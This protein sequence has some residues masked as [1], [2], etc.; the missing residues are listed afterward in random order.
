MQMHNSSGPMRTAVFFAED[1]GTENAIIDVFSLD[2]PS[3]YV[4]AATETQE[5][6][7]WLAY[8]QDRKQEDI[9]YS[10][11]SFR[12]DIQQAGM[13]Q[14]SPDAQPMPDE[15]QQNVPLP[16]LEQRPCPWIKAH[17]VRS[18]KPVPVDDCIDCEFV[19]SAFCETN[20]N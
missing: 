9:R 3:W 1:G 16:T 8:A 11:A 10:I 2:Q 13:L 20:P 12:R 6:D 5:P 14:P 7:K 4:V 19:K 15:I 18:G 17:C